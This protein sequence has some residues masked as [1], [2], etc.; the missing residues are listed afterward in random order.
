MNFTPSDEGD[1]IVALTITDPDDGNRTY[2]DSILVRATNVAP[3]VTINGL[4]SAGPE[5]THQLTATV[6]D[7]IVDQ[8]DCRHAGI[9]G[10]GD[11]MAV[12]GRAVRAQGP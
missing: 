3:A 6:T 5:G 12:I 1:Y 4:P 7:P 11:I 10:V 8:F 9:D 2:I